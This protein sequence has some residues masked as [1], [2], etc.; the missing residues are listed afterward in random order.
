M[1]AERVGWPTHKAKARQAKTMRRRQTKT[2]R[3][4]RRLEP[5]AVQR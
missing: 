2:A 1:S 5:K 3:A 4:A